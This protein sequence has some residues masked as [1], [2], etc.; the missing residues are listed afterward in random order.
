MKAKK[1]PA[2]KQ[3]REPQMLYRNGRPTAVLLDIK[4][5][6]RLLELAENEHDLRKLAELEQRPQPYRPFEEF[7]DEWER[8]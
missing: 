2:R 6:R 4:E 3:V 8:R 1:A 7:L 5:Y